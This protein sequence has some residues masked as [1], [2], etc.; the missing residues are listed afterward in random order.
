MTTIASLRQSFK[1]ESCGQWLMA[2]ERSTYVN[3]EQIT[4]LW[5]CPKCGSEFET[6]IFVG[7]EVPLTPEVVDT[8]LPNLLVA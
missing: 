8:F 3:E 6:S 7:Q 4:H 2:P 5:A 1:C